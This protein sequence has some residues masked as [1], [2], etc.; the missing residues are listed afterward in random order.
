MICS[1]VINQQLSLPGSDRS[2][3]EAKVKDPKRQRRGKKPLEMYMKKL[4]ER[5]LKDNKK[6]QMALKEFIEY[7]QQDLNDPTSTWM[8]MEETIRIM[9]EDHNTEINIS[10]RE[11]D[12]VTSS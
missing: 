7:F 1:I 10:I 5:F 2:A 9:K 12:Y 11:T 3:P 6:A 8:A 4:R